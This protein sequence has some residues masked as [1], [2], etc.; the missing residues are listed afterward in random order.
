MTEFKLVDVP[1]MKYTSLD[2]IDGKPTPRGEVCVRGPGVF[3][4][5]YKEP[6]KTAEAID[7]EGWL[8][9]GDIGMIQSNGSLKLID[10][11]K[12]I[13]KLQ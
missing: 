10:R 3:L 9:M 4:G 13:F 8:H 7:K 5:Y 11:K 1:E 12:N 2:N 6:E